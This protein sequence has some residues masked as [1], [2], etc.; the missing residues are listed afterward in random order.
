ME[1]EMPFI[2][3][4]DDLK[5]KPDS[6]EAGLRFDLL[7]EEMAERI[8]AACKLISLEPGECLEPHAQDYCEQYFFVLEGNG[9][10]ELD[11][12]AQQI[13]KNYMISIE[14]GERYE[15]RNDSDTVMEVLQF[16]IRT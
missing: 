5:P 15:V 13:A 1:V 10:L 11:G 2:I 14:P 12:G 9:T 4:R 6:R 16:V 8:G 7:G 3:H